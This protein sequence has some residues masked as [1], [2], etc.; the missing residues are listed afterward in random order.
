MITNPSRCIFQSD[1]RFDLR[2]ASPALSSPPSSS[3]PTRA[4]CARHRFKIH[5]PDDPAIVHDLLALRSQPHRCVRRSVSPPRT[6]RS[7]STS[8]NH[9]HHVKLIFSN[10][11]RQSN[12]HRCS[13]SSSYAEEFTPGLIPMAD[14]RSIIR[15][16]VRLRYDAYLPSS[17]NCVLRHLRPQSTGYASFSGATLSDCRIS[18]SIPLTCVMGGEPSALAEVYQHAASAFPLSSGV[19]RGVK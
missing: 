4:R 11:S 2:P 14:A 13:E 19:T 10:L 9:P 15:L 6:L 5:H 1:H 8:P 16:K 12:S 17:S 18:Q 3:S 7:S